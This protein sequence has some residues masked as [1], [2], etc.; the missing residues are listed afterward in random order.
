VS[1]ERAASLN[2]LLGLPT[3]IVRAIA[4]SALA[5][6]WTLRGDY[7]FGL[8]VL[9]AIGVIAVASFWVAQRRAMR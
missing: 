9:T 4:P 8:G 7:Q 1:R 5:V 2:G 6:L 3:A